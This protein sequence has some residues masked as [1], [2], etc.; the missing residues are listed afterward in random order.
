MWRE[1]EGS[2]LAFSVLGLLRDFLVST[3]I[4]DEDSV[5]PCGFT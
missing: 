4:I 5:K 3:T 2:G 1:L